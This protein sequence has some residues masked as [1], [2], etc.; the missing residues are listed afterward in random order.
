ML[1]D[2]MHNGNRELIIENISSQIPMLVLNAIVAGTK[3]AIQT[4]AF[5]DGLKAAEKSEVVL[6]GIPLSN[7]A[8]AA[9]HLLG[10]RKYEGND[11]IIVSMIKSRFL[12]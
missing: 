2:E 1:I 12:L 7:F 4:P 6:L 5:L 9:L 8:T 10:R 3:L 11:P